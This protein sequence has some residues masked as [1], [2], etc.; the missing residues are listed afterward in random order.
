M[1][2]GTGALLIIAQQLGKKKKTARTALPSSKAYCTTHN[3][4]FK[5]VLAL[6]KT[7]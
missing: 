2:Y 5:V 1:R 7:T 3:D 6:I 4:Q